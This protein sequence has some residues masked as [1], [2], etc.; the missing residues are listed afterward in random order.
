[1]FYSI[2]H[3]CISFNGRGCSKKNIVLFIYFSI[4]QLGS[5]A[6]QTP[7]WPRPRLM[8]HWSPRGPRWSRQSCEW[9]GVELAPGPSCTSM[10]WPVTISISI[11]LTDLGKGLAGPWMWVSK[12]D[13]C[14]EE[15]AERE[16]IRVWLRG[17]RV[18]CLRPL[19][20][21]RCPARER[22]AA[23]RVFH[24]LHWAPGMHI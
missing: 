22:R 2:M 21:S 3:L 7:S 12:G 10:A 17:W 23:H 24:S 11:I 1:M 9:M 16:R 4:I 15:P 13:C 8:F 19:P 6:E 18:L 20:A 14:Q 5:D